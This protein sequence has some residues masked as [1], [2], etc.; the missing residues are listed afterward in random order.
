MSPH[1]LLP[2][3]DGPAGGF[4]IVEAIVYGCFGLSWLTTPTPTR[5]SAARWVDVG[6]GLAPSTIGVAWL[7]SAA[8]MILCGALSKRRALETVGFIVAVGMAGTVSALYYGAYLLDAADGQVTG[9][10]LSSVALYGGYA[11]I[12]FWVGTP[13]P[14]WWTRAKRSRA[15]RRLARTITEGTEDEVS[16]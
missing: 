14:A 15:R 7:V 10:A 2:H 13:T 12:A 11:L 5:E 9:T 6:N 4:L 8:I 3:A 16:Q 1:R